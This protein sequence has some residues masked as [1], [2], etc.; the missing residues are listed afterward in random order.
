MLLIVCVLRY[1]SV[2]SLGLVTVLHR[3]RGS[4]SLVLSFL[5][6][7]QYSPAH[8]NSF[9]QASGRKY[10]FFLGVLAASAAIMKFYMNRMSLEVNKAGEKRGI[11]NNRDSIVHIWGC[12]QGRAEREKRGENE[13]KQKTRVPPTFSTHSLLFPSS[14]Q[15]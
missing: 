2:V 5:G 4:L 6:L 15:T 14:S 7:S 12:P 8:R 11:K 10:G 9:L 1:S 3:M 13:N